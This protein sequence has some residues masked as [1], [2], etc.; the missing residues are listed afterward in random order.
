MRK[1][2]KSKNRIKKRENSKKP[3]SY[4]L[5]T[6]LSPK[7]ELLS[8]AVH[9]AVRRALEVRLLAEDKVE[10]LVV[11]FIIEVDENWPGCSCQQR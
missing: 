11:E 4:L 8:R 5:I 2:G 10:Q 9:V 1:E 6:L 7:V 3:H